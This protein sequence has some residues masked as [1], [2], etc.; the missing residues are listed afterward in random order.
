MVASQQIVESNLLNKAVTAL[1]KHHESEVNASDKNLLLGNDQSI[2]VQFNL[3]RLP[4]KSSISSRPVRIEIPHSLH[5][6]NVHGDDDD[7]NDKLEEI[8][9][10]LIVKD[11]SKEGIQ[12][13][14]SQFPKE[15]SYIKKVLT[16]TSLRKKYGQYKDKRTLCNSYT[17]FFV[18]DRI[19]P[20][21]G[22][23]IGKSFFAKK[24]QPV[25]IKLTRKE[26]LPF[27]IE[28]CIKSTFMTIGAGT[29]VSVKA[30]STS[31]SSKTIEENIQ[32]VIQNVIPHVPRN[33]SNVSSISIKTDTS[34]ALP[35]HNKL[36]EELDAIAKMAKLEV[37]TRST[38]S[39]KRTL[40]D[41]S[42]K[43]VVEEEES[44]KTTKKQKKELSKSPLLKALKKK[45][46]Q[47]TELKEEEVK[48][49]EES[50]VDKKKKKKKRT[51]SD[52]DQMEDKETKK[53]EA[54]DTP[55]KKKKKK[56]KTAVDGDA[57]TPS[58]KKEVVKKNLDFVASKKF[59]GSK[60][61]Y[62]F[63]KD[64]KGVGY[65]KD[66]IPAPDTMAMEAFARS[67]SGGGNKSR[68]QS[69]SGGK[70]KNAGRRKGGRRTSY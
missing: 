7:E 36:R 47:E 27:V 45:K 48:L 68:R 39:K 23:L 21:V 6:L 50:K 33:A 30:A 14:I 65:Y 46:K 8:E 41:S 42:S 9:I 70:K 20:M 22:K 56:L 11:S 18:D 40:E 16:L 57:D 66:I 44:K 69:T 59:T 51:A 52:A 34:I 19:L 12:E 55:S 63:K 13:L 64:K 24:K 35:I 3:I 43:K 38:S 28:K 67:S 15:L 25:P 58:K 61:G 17:M 37:A 2:H 53:V 4:E 1:L 10:C 5:K 60:K 29:C 26:S 49:V 32:S 62:C 31:M 54:E